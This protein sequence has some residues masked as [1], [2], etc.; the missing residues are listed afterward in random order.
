M[1]VTTRIAENKHIGLTPPRIHFGF[2]Q[3][4]VLKGYTGNMGKQPVS[5]YKY[6]NK[7]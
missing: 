4:A 2:R 7:Y 1:P 6:Q 3:A 5:G